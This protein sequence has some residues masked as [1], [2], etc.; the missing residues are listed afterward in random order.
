MRYIRSESRAAPIRGSPPTPQTSSSSIWLPAKATSGDP[1]G[2]LPVGKT[3]SK[4]PEARTPPAGL[5][6]LLLGRGAA[7]LNAPPQAGRLFRICARTSIFC[8]ILEDLEEGSPTAS[9]ALLMTSVI[10][11]TCEPMNLRKSTMSLT[12]AVL[13]PRSWSTRSMNSGKD[14]VASPWKRYSEKSTRPTTSTPTSCT[15][16][17]AFGFSSSDSNSFFE[18]L[19]SPSASRPLVVRHS[20]SFE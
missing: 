18:I 20:C 6:G 9:W 16:L 3:D 8:A 12:V 19:M 14:S 2:A 10:S 1:A 7:H 11:R 17:A 5:H 4:V 15:I 13:D